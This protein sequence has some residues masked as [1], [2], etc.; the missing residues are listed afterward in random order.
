[1]LPPRAKDI[2]R[3]DGREEGRSRAGRFEAAKELGGGYWRPLSEAHK[4]GEV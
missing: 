1:V 2:P 4:F 3:E